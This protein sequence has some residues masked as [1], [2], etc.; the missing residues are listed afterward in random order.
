MIMDEYAGTSRVVTMGA[1]RS[2]EDCIE[3]CGMYKDA[4]RDL[5]P[6]NMRTLVAKVLDRMRDKEQKSLKRR[7]I[8]P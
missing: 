5:A 4:I 6:D 8:E 7:D 2:N 1:R 3:N